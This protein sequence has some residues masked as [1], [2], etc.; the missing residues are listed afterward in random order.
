MTY[1][2]QPIL[3]TEHAKHVCN[4]C[5]NPCEETI[6]DVCRVKIRAEALA[7]KKHKDRGEV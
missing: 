3:R 2:R 7:M 6:C 4:T 5:G 1:V